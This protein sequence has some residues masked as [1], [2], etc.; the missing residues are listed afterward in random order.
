MQK[1]G[2]RVSRVS[3]CLEVRPKK[4]PEANNIKQRVGWKRADGFYNVSP[5]WK[6]QR[7]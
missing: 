1:Q 4:I 7:D 3:V 5:E 2:H 6:R